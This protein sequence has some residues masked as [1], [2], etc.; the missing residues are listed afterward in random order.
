MG[1]AVVQERFAGEEFH[2]VG[3]DVK[4]DVRIH[5][6]FPWSVFVAPD[7]V[8]IEPAAGE[9]E[10]AEVRLREEAEGWVAGEV[11]PVILWLVVGVQA[12]G[13]RQQ[14]ADGDGVIREVRVA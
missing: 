5:R 8:V 6:L 9:E 13:V 10:L 11:H 12:G 1:V 7:G 3:D 14:H 4:A 2:E